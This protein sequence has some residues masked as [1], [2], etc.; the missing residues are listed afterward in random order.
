MPEILVP[1]LAFLAVTFIGAAAIT[2]R[3]AR[4]KRIALRLAENIEL[5]EPAA[6]RRLSGVPGALHRVGSAFSGGGHSGSLRHE[7]AR[8]GYHDAASPTIYIGAKMVLLIVSMLG[9]TILVATT[10][11]SLG[12]KSLV[13]LSSAAVAFF[14][15]N[16]YVAARRRHRC[17]DI[18]HHLPDAVDLLEICVSAGMGL[19]MAWNMVA[20]EIRRVCTALAD[21]MALTN[22][23]IHLGSSRVAAMRHMA[24]R[25]GADEL[26]SLVA[27]LVQSERFGTSISDALRT[28]AA[29]MRTERSAVAEEASEKTA[30][31]LIFPMILLIF[32]A[33]LIVIVGPAAIRFAELVFSG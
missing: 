27:V 21:E 12:V 33:M 19:D 1:L 2:W 16:A 18:R 6:Q 11:L 9:S 14:L 30:V 20:D 22:L 28:F 23:E 29:S 5:V 17:L 15:P 13:V 10:G 7:L 3:A 25:T 26:G 24:D 31:K 32:P 8:A 4:R